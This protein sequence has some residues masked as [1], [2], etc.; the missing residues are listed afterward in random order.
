[1]SGLTDL[2][3]QL[4]LA[5]DGELRGLKEEEARAL[6]REDRVSFLNFRR[7]VPKLLSEAQIFLLISNW[8]GFPRSILEGMRAGLPVIASRVG[9]IAEA[10]VDGHTG[11][12]VPRHDVESLRDRV[13]TLIMDPEQRR[14]MGAAGR[15][16]YEEHFTLDRLVARTVEMY[17]TLIGGRTGAARQTSPVA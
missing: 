13:R 14:R 6:G 8:E 3:C 16:R 11:F 2:D 7:D 17:E 9:G 5:G 12:V 15:A 4:D 10:V 1:L